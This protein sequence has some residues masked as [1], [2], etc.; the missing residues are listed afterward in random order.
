MSFNKSYIDDSD[1]FRL[2]TLQEFPDFNRWMTKSDAYICSGNFAATIHNLYYY[3]KEL[4]QPLWEILRSNSKK[5]EEAIKWIGKAWKE[6][7]Y[8]I[9]LKKMD[10]NVV[11]ESLKSLDVLTN[12]SSIHKQSELISEAIKKELENARIV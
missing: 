5:S 10:E 1:L 3:H 4:R 8:L 2:S 9:Y 7:E 11:L 6:I 12:K